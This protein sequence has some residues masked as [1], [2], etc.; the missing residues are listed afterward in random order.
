MT[1]ITY[2]FGAGASAFAIPTL[3]GAEKTF[4]SYL[5]ECGDDIRKVLADSKFKN[6]KSLMKELYEVSEVVVEGINRFGSPDTYCKFLYLTNKEQFI[7]TK[8]ILTFFF[9]KLQ[10]VDFRIDNRPLS[11][12]TTLL[13]DSLQMPTNIKIFNW[14]YDF[15]FQ[16][17]ANYLSEEKSRREGSANVHT[18]SVI[19]YYPKYG[20]VTN[21]NSLQLNP[22]DYDMIHLNGIAGFFIEEKNQLINSYM[23]GK[24]KLT[25]LELINDFADVQNPFDF[26][27]F[28]WEDNSFHMRNVLIPNFANNTEYLIIVG[29]SFPYFNR[30]IDQLI[31]DSIDTNGSLKKIYYQDL[32]RTG[33]FIKKQFKIRE[34]V[35]VETIPSKG[36]YH[37]P[38]EL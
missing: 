38:F 9:L 13:N 28:G 26:F 5:R 25:L 11:F 30:K 4:Q 32:F 3:Q 21:V 31:F 29:Y 14:N 15:Q 2:L 35:N 34:D 8:R 18:P 36:N 23:N 27:T 17:A 7:K 20:H 22:T 12:I 16:I 10:F 19:K 24:Q 37:I 1:N 33:D 6:H